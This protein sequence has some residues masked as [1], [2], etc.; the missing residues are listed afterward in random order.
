MVNLPFVKYKKTWLGLSGLLV[1]ASVAAFLV[2]GLKLGL[3]FTGGTLM[4]LQFQNNHPTTAQINEKLA[5]LDLGEINVQPVDDKNVVIRFKSVD[6]AT[7]AKM[8]QILVKEFGDPKQ[9]DS[10]KELR[11]DSVGSVIGQELKT[12]A[13]YALLV[14]FIVIIIYIAAS[15]RKVSWPVQSWK[16]GIVTILAGLH[17]VIA[18]VGLFAVLGRFFNIEVNATFIAALLTVLTYSVNDTIVILDR[19]RENLNKQ[20]LSFA[21]VVNLS[22]NETLARSINTTLT[23]LFTLAAVFFFGGESVH[24]FA[25]AM[26]WGIL[27]GAYSSI[28][29]ASP[30]LVVW[31]NFNRRKS[32]K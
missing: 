5:P 15:F 19:V 7:H 13:I 20:E 9:P 22:L 21:D 16:Y 3:D 6:E 25:L 29:V 28:F 2:W 27:L 18:V 23:V 10:I 26:L 32:V 31:Y 11:F 1:I 17:D 24:Y 14:V 12:K 30:L 4:Q 8:R